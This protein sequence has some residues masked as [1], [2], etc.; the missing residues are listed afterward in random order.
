MSR[1]ALCYS[2]EHIFQKYVSFITVIFQIHSLYSSSMFL[3]IQ[4]EQKKN[5]W[6]D[7]NC[8]LN[9]STMNC[10]FLYMTIFFKTNP[11]TSIDNEYNHERLPKTSSM[12]R[13]HLSVVESSKLLFFF[14]IRMHT[15][16]KQ[17][18]PLLSFTSSH[19]NSKCNRIF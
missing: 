10:V 8:F 6:N 2:S 4:Q 11:H 16:D 19:A 17:H 13:I 18:N 3:S 15:Q 12:H 14:C 9:W 1:S 5:V 7:R